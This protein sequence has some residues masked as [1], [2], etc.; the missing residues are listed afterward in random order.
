MTSPRATTHLPQMSSTPRPIPLPAVTIR[1]KD[2]MICQRQNLRVLL[3]RRA[4]A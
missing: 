3:A 2:A 4:Y 1:N